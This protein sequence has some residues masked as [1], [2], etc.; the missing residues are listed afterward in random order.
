[1]IKVNRSKKRLDSARRSRIQQLKDTNVF[2]QS[3]TQQQPH[4]LQQHFAS[5]LQSQSRGIPQLN[6]N[7]SNEI[8]TKLPSPADKANKQMLQVETDF[9]MTLPIT[10]HKPAGTIT[11]KANHPRKKLTQ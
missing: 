9:N 7:H 6:K 11:I 3:S 4:P 2:D 1:M 5:T 10:I 8:K